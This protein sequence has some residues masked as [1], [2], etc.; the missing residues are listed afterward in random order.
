MKRL[1][2]V[3]GLAISLLFDAGASAETPKAESEAATIPLSEIVTTSPQKGMQQIRDVL[4]QKGNAQE[5]ET[6]DGYLRQLLSG[7]N[8]GSNVFLVDAATIY[9]AL[10]ASYSILVGSRSADTP[11]AVN[12]PKPKRGG[13]W[14]IA[15]LGS[16]PSD[17]TWWSIESVSVDK[18]KVVLSYRKSKSR[19]ATRD[20]RRYY[21]WIPLR[22]LDPG[23]YELEL[24]DADNGSVTLMRRVEITATPEGEE[25]E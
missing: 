11:V 19:S 25:T 2:F 3:V 12:T 7:T 21:Y 22:K 18:G 17:P 23:I 16:G 15:Y 4:Q 1:A 14:L 6:A 8:G 13:H 20:L 9:D 5:P 24:V 10:S